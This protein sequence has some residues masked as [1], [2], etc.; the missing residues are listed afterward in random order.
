LAT[1]SQAAPPSG[2]PGKGPG[3][4]GKGKTEAAS[5]QDL[6]NLAIGASESLAKCLALLPKCSPQGLCTII[7]T[8]RTLVLPGGLSA[9]K[10]VQQS[11]AIERPSSSS[12][13]VATPRAATGTTAKQNKEPKKNRSARRW[14]ELSA[15][16]K[17]DLQEKNPILVELNAS[18]SRAYANLT[19][20]QKTAMRAFHSTEEL[21]GSGIPQHCIQ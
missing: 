7:S 6:E 18:Q 1:P 10:E 4:K 2:Q 3:A 13:R 8:A 11:L 17:R 9:R 20:E 14:A 12:G 21:E 5:T 19:Q 16:K 15:D